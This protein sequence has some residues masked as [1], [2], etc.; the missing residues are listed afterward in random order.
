MGQGTP[1]P[2]SVQTFILAPTFLSTG[3]WSALR[4]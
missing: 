3:V 1:Q 4:A 2:R